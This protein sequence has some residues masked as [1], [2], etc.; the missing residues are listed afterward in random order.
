MNVELLRKIEAHILEEPKRFI[1][2]QYIVEK[3]SDRPDVNGR[4]FAPCGTAACI[5]GWACLLNN[6]HPSDIGSASAGRL[7]ELNWDQRDRLFEPSFWP[8]EFIDGT[9]GDGQ[10]GTA[11]VAVARIEH[12]IK[13]EGRE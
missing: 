12:F 5:A 3:S 9:A 4:D 1:M 2:S 13:T 11:E 10:A 8:K 7:L 6:V